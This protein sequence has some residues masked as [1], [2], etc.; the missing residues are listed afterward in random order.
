M[1]NI[2]EIKDYA[3]ERVKDH[4]DSLE[5][6]C[7]RDFTDTLLME[8]EKVPSQLEASRPGGAKFWVLHRW[9]FSGV[10]RGMHFSDLYY[11]LHLWCPHRPTLYA[12]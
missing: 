3:L 6:S 7:P 12:F 8:M 11:G 4:R 2:S 9:A 1:K 5:P 10:G